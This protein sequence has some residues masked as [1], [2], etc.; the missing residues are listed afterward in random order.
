LSE[1]S[2]PLT[3]L[4]N[5]GV[6][7]QRETEMNIDLSLTQKLDFITKGLSAKALLSINNSLIS[8][9]GLYDNAQHIRASSGGSN[10]ILPIVRTINAA[11]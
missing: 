3:N 8:T 10:K 5:L 6:F 7:K 11:S 4:Y 2:N 1:D 9:G